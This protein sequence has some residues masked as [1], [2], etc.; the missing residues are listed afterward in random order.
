MIQQCEE[1]CEMGRDYPRMLSVRN[2]QDHYP[3]Q[4]V[5][6]GPSGVP[7]GEEVIREIDQAFITRSSFPD[8]DF[9]PSLLKSETTRLITGR[10]QSLMMGPADSFPFPVSDIIMS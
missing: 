8:L 1:G 4:D 3:N 5:Y 7:L 10:T 2:S 9:W 6:T